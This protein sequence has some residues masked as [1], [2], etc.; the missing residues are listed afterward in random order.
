MA[1]RSA[2]LLYT[3]PHCRELGT[4]LALF[5]ADPGQKRHGEQGKGGEPGEARLPQRHDDQCCKDRAERASG[6]T[7]NLEETLGQPLPAAG[8]IARHTG[9]LRVEYG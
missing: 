9:R 7:A 1:C 3:Y 2:R 5:A 6:L 4:D 8:R